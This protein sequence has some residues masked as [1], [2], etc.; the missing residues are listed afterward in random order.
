[1][2]TN[3]RVNH[4]IVL[5]LAVTLIAA[6]ITAQSKYV[7]GQISLNM[8]R[9]KTS[10]GLFQ[11]NI[12]STNSI[13][14]LPEYGIITE[15]G[16]MFGLSLGV[17]WSR[18]KLSDNSSQLIAGVLDINYRLGFTQ[19]QL[20]PFLESGLQTFIGQYNPSSN[21]NEYFQLNLPLNAGLM[22]AANERW[23]AMVTFDVFKLNH[24][25]SGS[26]FETRL[27]FANSGVLNFSMIR[28]LK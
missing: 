5:A 13:L 15:S 20:R 9:E 22:F 24:I 7:G 23:T 11:S 12:I 25:Q 17:F 6:N 1:M 8:S 2:L 21:G 18:T 27:S 28:V 4:N 14:I 19:N 3:T 10:F 26:Q 16:N